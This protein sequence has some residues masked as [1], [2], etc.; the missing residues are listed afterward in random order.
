MWMLAAGVDLQLLDHRVA[1]V[2]LGQHALDRDLQRPAR[3]TALHL[4]ERRL[5]DA[6][7]IVE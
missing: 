3:E 6:A 7:R 1:S 2:A 5:A 4:V